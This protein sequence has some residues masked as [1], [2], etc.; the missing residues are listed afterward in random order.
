MNQFSNI[1]TVTLNSVSQGSFGAAKAMTFSMAVQLKPNTA[2]SA[3][4]PLPE[5]QSESSDGTTPT[6]S[7]VAPS[8]AAPAVRQASAAQAG[9][10][11]ESTHA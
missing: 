8:L 4:T 3:P 11:K 2:A 6:A 1:S 10:A 5:L 7:P 9:G